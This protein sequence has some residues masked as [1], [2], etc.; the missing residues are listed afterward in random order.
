M[1]ETSNKA[2]PLPQFIPMRC[3]VCKGRGDVNWGKE[4]CKAC[5]GKGYIKVPPQEADEQGNARLD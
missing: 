4:T 3:P 1:E 2:M 5:N